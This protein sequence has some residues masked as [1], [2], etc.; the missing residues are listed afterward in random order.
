VASASARPAWATPMVSAEES[1]GELLHTTTRNVWQSLE[2]ISPEDW[3]GLELEPHWIRVG[4]GCGAMDEHWFERS[5]GAAQKGSMQVCEIAGRTF[6]FCA[7]PPAEPPSLPAGPDGPRQLL[8][9][10]H[11]VLHFHAGRRIPILSVPG[12]GGGSFVHVIEGGPGKPPLEL[13]DGW[14]LREIRLEGSWVVQLPAPTSVFF[15]PNRDS[16][17]GPVQELPRSVR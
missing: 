4:I 16:Y 13:P 14:E 9:D 17:Q 15:F 2:P 6:G 12:E 10:K 11:H 5:P 1:H 8:V 3:K 7:R